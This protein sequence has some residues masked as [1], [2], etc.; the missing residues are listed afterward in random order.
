MLPSR[1]VKVRNP[2]DADRLGG[3]VRAVEVADATSD[4]VRILSSKPWIEELSLAG[5]D[6]LAGDDFTFVRALVRLKALDLS[7]CSLLESNDLR[8]ITISCS[9]LE[10]V[11]LVMCELLDDEAFDE[12]DNLARLSYLDLSFCFQLTDVALRRIAQCQSLS[13]L[14]LTG[15]D[16]ITDEGINTIASHV[17]IRHLELPGG[18]RIGDASL[19][20][21]ADCKTLEALTI[22]ELKNVTDVGLRLLGS[23]N[24]LRHVTIIGCPSVTNKGLEQLLSAPIVKL[25]IGGLPTVENDELA[26]QCSERGVTLRIFSSSGRSY[27]RTDR[28]S[29]LG[30]EP[31]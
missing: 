17:P 22:R 3:D 18:A 20:Q 21:L 9:L 27:I 11:A 15:C 2:Q 7:G 10:H 1:S 28:E 13:W 8:G 19:R 23:S 26:Q 24:N 6:Q 12:T 25:S 30:T 31:E 14:S 5:A 16:L 4:V 29:R